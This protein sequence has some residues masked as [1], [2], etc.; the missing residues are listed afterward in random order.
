MPRMRVRVVCGFDE[1]AAMCSPT[2]AFNKVDLPELGR[3]ISAKVAGLMREEC[4]GEYQGLNATMTGDVQEF[5]PAAVAAL[6]GG[7]GA[8]GWLVLRRGR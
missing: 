8:P 7:L 3:P 2:S 1:T 6:V 4:R 5:A